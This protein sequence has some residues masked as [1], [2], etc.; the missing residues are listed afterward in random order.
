MDNEKE[1]PKPKRKP[2]LVAVRVVDRR[3]ANAVLVE[4]QVEDDFA[5]CWLPP[6]VVSDDKVSED[7]LEKGIPYGVD[8]AKY[9][10]LAN[11][12][13]QDIARELR[14]RGV[15]TVQDTGKPNAVYRAFAG[16]IKFQM[17]DMLRRAGKAEEGRK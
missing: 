11:P 3:A 16:A 9:I 10:T 8:W 6:A 13:P 12:S 4:Y 1:A 7:D 14:A 2:K 15:W 5:R 17:N